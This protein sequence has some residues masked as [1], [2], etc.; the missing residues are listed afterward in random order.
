[1][2]AVTTRAQVKWSI[3]ERGGAPQKLSISPVSITLPGRG[4]TGG[5]AAEMAAA[6]GARTSRRHGTRSCGSDFHALPLART[7]LRDVTGNGA[8][9]TPVLRLK[10]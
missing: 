2:S 5:L 6:Q 9:A 1:M 4:L 10:F 7:A 8:P 3:P